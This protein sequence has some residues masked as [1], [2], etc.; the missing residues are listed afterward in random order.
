MAG[1]T[2]RAMQIVTPRNPAGGYRLGLVLI[3][4]STIAWSTAGYFTRLIPLDSWTLLFWRGLF[5]AAT[6]LAFWAAQRRGRA[7]GRG[8]IGRAGWLL[9]VVSALGM[10]AFVSAMKLTTVAH[11]AIIYATIPFVAAVLG[12]LVLRERSPAA[13]LAASAVAC[14]G[15]VVMVAAG[16]GEG[17]ALGDA[18]AVAMTLAM[19]VMIVI[20]R[21][22]HDIPMLPVSCLSA[23]LAALIALPF[24]TLS[25]GP[26]ELGELAL[27]GST[28]MG[29]GLI[30]FML[31]SRLVPAA[32]TALIGALEAPLAPFWVWLAF[33]ETPT[34][35]TL[36][37]G[38]LVLAAVLAHVVLAG[39]RPVAAPAAG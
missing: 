5:G 29:L 1:E 22:H 21:G 31:G 19:G 32:E 11:V 6:C 37:G 15:V 18:L 24:A 38:A 17:G 7:P 23:A 36:A 10:T 25:V 39:R 16:A 26:R 35:A 28:N 20:S 3:L 9:A 4:L 34:P 2:A 14:A 12:W 13:T 27:F 33:A 8:R 30:L